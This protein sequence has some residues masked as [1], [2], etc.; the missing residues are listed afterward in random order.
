MFHHWCC[1]SSVASFFL[2]FA[3]QSFFLNTSCQRTW[4]NRPW[5]AEGIIHNVTVFC[6]FVCRIMSTFL[7]LV[8]SLTLAG[9]WPLLVTMLLQSTLGSLVALVITRPGL[10]PAFSL[11]IYYILWSF[12][13]MPSVLWCF[14]LGDRKGILPVKTSASKPLGMAVNGSEPEVRIKSFGLSCED[15]QDKDDWRLRIMGATG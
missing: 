5:S 15:A 2:Y 11:C 14:W 8:T 10:C 6:I 3:C 1:S 12:G 4:P 13:L 9:F 7:M